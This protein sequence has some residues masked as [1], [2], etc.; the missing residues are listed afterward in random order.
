MNR[1]VRL[2]TSLTAAGLLALGSASAFAQEVVDPV[3]GRGFGPGVETEVPIVQGEQAA[4]D[5]VVQ[6]EQVSG[7]DEESV[8]LGEQAAALPVTLPRTGGIAS[9]NLALGL[10]SG[11]AF[12]A[13]GLGLVSRRPRR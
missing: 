3:S 11:L 7:A 4:D 10:I 1:L 12:T 9:S 13:T 2:S 6:G 8:V 5:A